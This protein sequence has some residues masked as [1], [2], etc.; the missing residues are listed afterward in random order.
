MKKIYTTFIYCFQVFQ[1]RI[2]VYSIIYDSGKYCHLLQPWTLF[3]KVKR[4]KQLEQTPTK[5]KWFY[6]V[7]SSKSS[8]I[9]NLKR[10][11]YAKVLIIHEKHLRLDFCHINLNSASVT[12]ESCFVHSVRMTEMR[13]TVPVGHDEY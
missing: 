4:G 5:S 6:R 9:S 7:E 13:Y 3:P 1:I 12:T 10:V 8:P 2:T 11:H